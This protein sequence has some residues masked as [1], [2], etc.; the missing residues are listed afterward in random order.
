MSKVF[1]ELNV[2]A[3]QVANILICHRKHIWQHFTCMNC[4]SSRI[5]AKM[6]PPLHFVPLLRKNWTKNRSDV[7]HREAMIYHLIAWQIGRCILYQTWI[8]FFHI[9]FTDHVNQLHE[10]TLS[11]KFQF[12]MFF[13][14]SHQFHCALVRIKALSKSVTKK[15][16]WGEVAQMQ[17]V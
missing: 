14:Y 1:P 8:F 11:L 10:F 16:H 12:W 2:N 5:W 4:S 15:V 17:S 13:F 6:R 9:F 7:G 3:N